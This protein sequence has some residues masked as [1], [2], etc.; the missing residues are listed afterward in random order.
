MT[1]SFLA[2]TV[3]ILAICHAAIAWADEV[4]LKNGDRLTGDI[5]GM[6][7]GVLKFKSPHVGAVNIEWSDVQRLTSDKTFTIQMTDDTVMTGTL[8]ASAPLD[9]VAA[10]GPVEAVRYSGIVNI[11]GA[12]ARGNSDT[13]A[14]NA[15]LFFSL[16]KDRQRFG[17]EGKYNYAEDNRTITQRNSLLRPNYD[18]FLTKKVYATSYALLEQD[19]LQDLRLRRTLGVG[20]GYQFFDTR[21]T[22]LSAELGVASVHEDWKSREDRDAAAARWAVNWFTSVIPDR[23][24]VYHRQEGYRDL[25][26]EKAIRIRADQGF[27]VPVYRQ[28]SLNL[29][30]DFRYNSNPAP[31]RKTSDHLYIFGVSYA[32]P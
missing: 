18:Y 22:Q 27:R 6:E 19:T 9:T 10:I 2:K 3:L 29:E 25:N 12:A 16:R 5:V 23:L 17:L 32:I 31:G 30:Y 20:L 21:T 8:P 7:K 26:P 13:T 15:S 11:G 24:I 1:R 28:F 4:V 14:L